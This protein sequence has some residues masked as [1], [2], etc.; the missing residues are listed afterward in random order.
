MNYITKLQLE[1]QALEDQLSAVRNSV[2]ELQMYYS[3][4]KF[5]GDDNGYAY[6]RTDILPRLARLK[7]VAQSEGGKLY[8]DKTAELTEG[9]RVLRSRIGNP[10]YDQT[11]LYQD[12][13]ANEK[14]LG[15]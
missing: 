8:W 12:I 9:L 5:Q 10:E 14:A 4:E 1:K 15:L 7:E 6:T 2:I 11:S 3:S 13:E